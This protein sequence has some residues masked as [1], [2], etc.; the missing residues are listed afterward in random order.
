MA[1]RPRRAGPSPLLP[2][3]RRRKRPRSRDRVVGLLIAVAAFGLA[4]ALIDVGPKHAQP[5]PVA[6]VA[7]FANLAA[8][9]PLGLP[10]GTPPLP[11]SGVG[12]PALDPLQ[13][14]LANPPDAG[15]LFNLETGQVLWQLNPYA[16]R[17]IASLTKM[18][19]ALVVLNRLAPQALVPIT[20]EAVEMPGSKVGVL[21][22]GKK[23]TVESLL[24]GLM[25]PS[26]NDAAQALAAAAGPGVNRF[27]EEMNLEAARLGL[28]CTRFSNPSGYYNENNYSCPVDLA[29]L[30]YAVLHQPLLARIVASKTAQVPAPIP[31]GK[32]YLVNNNPLLLYN[33]PGANGVKTG[34]TE[35]A[36]TSLVASARRDGI[37]LGVVL[38][39]SPAPGTQAQR[40]FDEAFERVYHQPH[41]NEPQIPGGA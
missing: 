24:Y 17:P 22:L 21:P 41:Q 32:I 16:R 28:G 30:A 11:L 18:M 29:E 10:L 5:D 31:G 37:E 39:H 3:A 23:M 9:S 27:A 1:A 15:L 35:A 2:P 34:Y 25:L 38:L 13:P 33:Y 20:K 12:D 40:L 6:G 4:A 36:G 14:H 26:G 19:T 8:T 7:G